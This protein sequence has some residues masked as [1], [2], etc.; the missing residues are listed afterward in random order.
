MIFFPGRILLLFVN[1]L[2]FIMSFKVTP[3]NLREISH[4][5]SPFL[6]VYIRYPPDEDD[7]DEFEVVAEVV[8]EVED[9][10]AADDVLF[11]EDGS[12]FLCIASLWPILML[13]LTPFHLCSSDHHTPYLWAILPSV[14]PFHTV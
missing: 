6:T 12:P 1:P 4:S 3:S 14:S 10:D 11:A 9:D 8:F 7:A 5:V 13:L 2:S